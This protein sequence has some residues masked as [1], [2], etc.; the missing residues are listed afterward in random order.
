MFVYLITNTINQKK[1]V[2]KSNCP[3]DRWCTH[4]Y[5]ANRGAGYVVHKALRK[6]GLDAFTFEVL[7]AYET[8]KASLEGEIEW[9]ARLDSTI[10]GWGYNMTKGGEGGAPTE[11]QLKNKGLAL[12]QIFQQP[13]VKKHRSEMSIAMWQRPEYRKNREELLACPIFRD[14]RSQIMSELWETD[15]Q[16]RERCFAA[17]NDPAR[18]EQMRANMFRQLAETDIRQRC[19]ETMQTPEYKAAQLAGVNTPEHKALQSK[20]SFERWADPEYKQKQCENM[21]KLNN[22]P[23]RL[24]VKARIIELRTAGTP[25]KDICAEVQRS[26]PVIQRVLKAAGLVRP[27]AKYVHWTHRKTDTDGSS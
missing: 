11:E 27:T 20:I 9:I 8:Q 26:M 19:I 23:E 10:H 14:R 7:E 24:S 12:S 22:T 17:S 25:L 3:D 5:E 2:G 18:K 15:E 21:Q 6:Y 4:Q 16:F 1:Y 13:E